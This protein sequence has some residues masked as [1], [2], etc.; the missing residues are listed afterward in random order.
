MVWNTFNQVKEWLYKYT[1]EDPIY[2][3]VNEYDDVVSYDELIDLVE[4]KQSVENEDDFTY[5]RNVDGYRF[6]DEEFL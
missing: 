1:V 2:A 6:A 5:S 3:I 4:R